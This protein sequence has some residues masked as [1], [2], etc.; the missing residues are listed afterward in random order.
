ML[1]KVEKITVYYGRIR[2]IEDIS[3]EVKEGTILTIIGAN[4]AGK[5]TTLNALMGVHPAASGEIWYRG[6]RIDG[7]GVDKIVIS[8]I[9]MVPEGR[10]LFPHMSVLDNLK[11]GAF[12]RKDKGHVEA[13]LEHVFKRFPILKERH[14]Q[15]AESLSG[16]EQQM[17]AI[18]RAMMNRPKVLLLDEPSLGLAPLFVAEIANIITATNQDGGTIILVEQNANLAL[19]VAHEALVLETG[20][21]ALKGTGDELLHNEQVRK[22]YLGI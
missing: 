14:H 22:A 2:A 19:K 13:D 21:V 20:S 5:T 18:A 4:G 11:M 17:L 1:L 8:G 6:E 12:L 7:W 10:C 15:H 9:S 3:F 16:G